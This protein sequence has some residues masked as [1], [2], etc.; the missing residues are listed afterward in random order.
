MYYILNHAGMQFA[1]PMSQP[2]YIWVRPWPQTYSLWTYSIKTLTC[3]QGKALTSTLG[4]VSSSMALLECALQDMLNESNTM[5][6][7]LRD[8]VSRKNTPKIQSN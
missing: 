4:T 5:L 6:K 7:L 8:L 3:M 1:P 2:L